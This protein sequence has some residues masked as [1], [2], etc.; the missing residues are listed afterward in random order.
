MPK[1]NWKREI[2]TIPNLLSLFRL[3]LIPVYIVMYLN[4][5]TSL[6][7]YLS[8]GILTLSCLTDMFD[9]QIA[10]RFNMISN[11]G[12]ILDPLAD[13]LTQFALV[14]CLAVRY[15]I[16]WAVIVLFVVKE[17]FQ[18]IA[19]GVSIRKGRV[20][21][22]ALLSGKICTT[23]LFVSLVFLVMFHSMDML[24]VNIITA[25]DFLVLL[26]AFID[27]V[28]AYYKKDSRFESVEDATNLS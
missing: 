18:L 27:Y 14:I 15:P 20:L 2:F 5:K 7:Y 11:I 22:G 3:A 4:A 13:K 26:Y 1:I 23:I 8:A 21:K 24:I 28:V 9:G 25:V 19:L 17:T 12:K 6:D 16:M 10:R